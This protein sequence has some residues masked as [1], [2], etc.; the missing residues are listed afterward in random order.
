MLGCFGPDYDA[1]DFWRIDTLKAKA[2]WRMDPYMHTWST[3]IE[4]MWEERKQYV[5]TL[6]NIPS[7]ALQL[8]GYEQSFY[9]DE[10]M[11]YYELYSDSVNTD[12][13]KPVFE[14]NKSI[15]Q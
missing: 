9:S 13:L 3:T 6:D 5:C 8:Y 10:P 11:K 4:E 1:V 7:C 2:K 14:I 12:N 15:R